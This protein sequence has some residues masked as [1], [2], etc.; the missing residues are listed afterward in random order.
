MPLLRRRTG[1][2]TQQRKADP[3]QER[4]AHAAPEPQVFTGTTILPEEGAAS[5][6]DSAGDVDPNIKRYG[7]GGNPGGAGGFGGAGTK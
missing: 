3:P 5:R 7:Q 4:E 2:P 1:R 6:I